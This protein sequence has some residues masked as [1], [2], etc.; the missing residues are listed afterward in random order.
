MSEQE[1]ANIEQANDDQVIE[2]E[3]DEVKEL[4][5]LRQYMLE[6][7]GNLS[8]MMLQFEKQKAAM[9]HRSREIEVAIHQ[10]GAK[11]RTDKQLD[12]ELTYELKLPTAEGEKAYFIRKDD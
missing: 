10:A 11:L 7:E 4:H 12:A 1:N 8:A 3:W 9:L 6:V 2:V 5:Q